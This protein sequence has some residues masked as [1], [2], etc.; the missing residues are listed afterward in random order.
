M[1][2][3]MAEE[4][5]SVGFSFG[6]PD[7]PAPAMFA[8]IAPEPGGLERRSWGAYGAAGFARRGW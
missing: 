4:Y 6:S 5:V 3:G 7:S 2:H 1:Q 8:Y